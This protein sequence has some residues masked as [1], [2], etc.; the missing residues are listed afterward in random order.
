MLCARKRR[1][2]RLPVAQYHH[3]HRRRGFFLNITLGAVRGGML[4]TQ[5]RYAV[6]L[7][8]YAAHMSEGADIAARLG[9]RKYN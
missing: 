1:G 2:A 6:L 7:P 5:L 9:L 8:S 3:R 4:A